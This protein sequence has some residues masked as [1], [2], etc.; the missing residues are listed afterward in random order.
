M[1]FLS[2]YHNTLK[3]GILTII[4]LKKCVTR[5]KKRI[6]VVDFHIMKVFGNLRVFQKLEYVVMLLLAF[7][8]P[9]HWYAAQCCEVALLTVAVLKIV[10]DQ[11]CRFNERQMRFKWVYI[12]FAATWLV[13]LIGM[14]YTENTHVGWIQVSKKLGFLIFPAVF[15]F[16]DM[17]YLNKD[18]IRVIFYCFATACLL[19]CL[20]NLYW[21]LYDGYVLGHNAGL[22]TNNNLMR[23]YYVHHTYMSMYALLALAFSSVEII[24]VKDWRLKI[25][26]IF[27]SISMLVFVVLLDSRA[28]IICLCVELLILLVWLGF[29]K[30]KLLMSV[31]FTVLISGGI[32]PFAVSRLNATIAKLSD[33]DNPD[34]RMVEMR[35]GMDVV[36]NHLL[37]GVG[38]GDRSDEMEKAY[39]RY[40]DTLV[41]EIK[42]ARAIDE[43]E[44]VLC[45]DEM[46]S[47]IQ[48]ASRAGQW[49]VPNKRFYRFID[50]K[51]VEYECD[52]ESVRGMAVEYIYVENA[53]KHDLNAHNQYI[54]T[55]IS[56]GIVGLLLLVACFLI[57][58]VI[59]VRL[60]VFDVVCFAFLVTIAINAMFESVFEMQMGIIFFCFF[61]QV[62]FQK[63]MGEQDTLSPQVIQD[64]KF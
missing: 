42:P 17:S 44:F 55:M 50:N 1:I 18:R 49:N 15:L 2:E 54:D 29:I 36:E 16:S 32:A 40:R 31:I 64:I 12:V 13:Y 20:M 56:I 41:A 47:G 63:N 10:F 8:I 25:Y 35:C 23:I 3:I 37:F 39:E 22:I 48:R 59:A 61:W 57:P 28:G 19:F 27:I 30:K 24:E 26:H 14:I 62:F 52:T 34:I 43:E 51:P 38:T 46:L 60:K 45:R 53:I 5:Q 33:D 7:A 9:F 11:K 21:T 6:F 58:A 4:F